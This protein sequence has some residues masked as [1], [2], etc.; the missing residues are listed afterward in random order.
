MKSLSC[1]LISGFALS[2]VASPVI[3]PR[4]YSINERGMIQKSPRHETGR[5]INVESDTVTAAEVTSLQFYAEYAAASYCNSNVSVGTAISCDGDACAEVASAGA[6]VAATFSGV[7]TDVE[8]FLSTDD[9]NEL[10][11]VSIRGSSSVRNWIT[12]FVFLQ[13]GCD[14][15]FGCL[16]HA[17]F[18][19]AWLE[20]EEKLLATLATETAA[21]PSYQIVFTGHS[22][23]AAVATVAAAFARNEGYAIDLYTYGS[24][25][26]G[27]DVFVKSVTDQAGSE[28]RVTHLDDPVPR[29]PPILLN[30]RHT[31]PEYW[32]SDG[33]SNTTD[34]TAADI[35]V[36]DGF[37]NINCNAGTTGLDTDAHGYYFQVIDGCGPGG[38]EFRRRMM[39]RDVDSNVTRDM[40]TSPP[41]DVT[42]AVLLAKLDDWVA[43]DIEFVANLS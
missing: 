36:C 17:G 38:F 13:V 8:G 15:V 31:S 5:E 40:A 4:V 25:R 32:L 30:Y 2:A 33:T 42:D 18:M 16:I 34:Y 11:V 29:L 14:L 19:T 1:A 26:V 24:P 3:D 20:I 7:I 41:Q 23:G 37:A 27:N 43:Q 28:N 39:A 10:I 12:D 6:T 9:T 21:H 22:L 35:K